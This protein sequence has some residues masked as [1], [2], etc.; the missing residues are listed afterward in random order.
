M[1]KKKPIVYQNKDVGSKV[2][3]EYLP[4]RDFRIFGIDLPKIKSLEPTNLPVVAANELQM[5][6][7]FLL[8]DDSYLIVD[9][10]SDYSEEKKSKYMNYLARL[11]ARL[12]NKN[13]KYPPIHVL[14]I[15]T[16]DVKAGMTKP[17]LD[18][19][20]L[21]LNL[22]EVFLTDMN[23][24]MILQEIGEKLS[25]DEGL[26][27]DDQL[28]LIVS[29]LTFVGKEAKV[30]AAHRAIL[31]ADKIN[32]ERTERFVLQM[33]KVITNKFI[34]E[35]DAQRIKEAI[36]MTKVDRL[37]EEEKRQAVKDAVDKEIEKTTADNKAEKERIARNM[38]K[39]GMSDED[40]AICVGYTVEQVRALSGA[41][42]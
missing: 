29:P 30:E 12:Y 40:V 22:L 33:I 34:S 14:V 23:G 15:Y 1:A 19:A 39:L 42:A 41:R 17:V 11:S 32:D 10:E 3:A 13:R 16:A 2:L 18:I 21:R 35:E 8:E 37:F 7:L 28:R 36:M 9:Y 31:I 27:A 24:E 20:G 25:R 6:N 38:Q 26:S 5:D 4:G